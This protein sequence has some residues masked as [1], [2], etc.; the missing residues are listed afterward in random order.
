MS[1]TVSIDRSSLTLAALVI[2]NT[3]GAY[4]LPE[5]GF[6]EPEFDQRQTFASDSPDTAGSL[7]IQSVQGVGSFGCT[8]YTQA[9]TAAA[10]KAQK[11]AL[12][13]AV[14]QFSYTLSLTIVGAPDTYAAMP[15]R[16]SWGEVDS[17][18]VGA[19]LARAAVT[20]PVQ[21]LGA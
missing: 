20:I 17:G 11:R 15:G 2:S 10:L 7:L 14:Y 16:V 9:S 19:L 21:P 5:D 6:T 13:A 4:W 3:P 12:E 1:L 18:M 8:V